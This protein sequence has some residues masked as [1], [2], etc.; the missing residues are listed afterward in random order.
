MQIE[1]LYEERSCEEVYS[2]QHLIDVSSKSKEDKRSQ[3]LVYP[4]QDQ[5][6]VNILFV[7]RKNQD[8]QHFVHCNL[9][10][11]GNCK[12]NDDVNDEEDGRIATFCPWL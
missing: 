2:N 5:S 6:F 10:V 7:T 12:E 8:G 9:K 3:L 11:K 4:W 1:V